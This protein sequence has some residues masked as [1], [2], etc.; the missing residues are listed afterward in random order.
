MTQSLFTAALL[1]P[2]AA[3]PDG[4]ID[5][6][7]RPAPQRFAVYRN[8]V[9]AGLT[10]ALEE[11]FPV[12]RALLGDA[13]FAAMAGDFLRQHPPTSPRLMLYGDALPQYLEHFAPVAHLGYLPD[14]ARLELAMRDSYHAADAAPL[15]ADALAR[16]SPEDLVRSRIS[17]APAVRLVRSAWPIHAIWLAHTGDGPPPLMAAQD[18]LILRPAFDPQPHA[19]PP[20]TAALVRALQEGQSLGAAIEAAG[21]GDVQTVLAVLVAG[22]GIQGIHPCD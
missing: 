14:M 7:G 4:L 5:P 13:F 6:Q 11:G 18:V 17:L 8:N 10:K 12:L 21:T 20:G 15:A 19:L 16:L 22:G 3:L 9:V 1:A 2:D